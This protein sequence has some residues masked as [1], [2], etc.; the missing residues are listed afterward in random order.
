L[1]GGPLALHPS[2]D[3]VLQQAGYTV[4]RV[5]GVNQYATA[6]A[7]AGLMPN[8]AAVFEATGLHF[9]DAL[10]AVPAAIKAGGA[11]LLTDGASQ[12]GETAAYLQA[13][14]GVAR[15]AIGGPLAAAGADPGAEAVYGADL[16]DTSAAVAARFFSAPT[17][18]G[19]AS[20]ANFPDALA[21]GV[22]MGMPGH[23]GPMLLVSP[24]LPLPSAVAG[25]LATRGSVAG[26]FLFGGPLAV[27]DAVADALAL[28][29]P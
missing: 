26:A 22:F 14:P 10:S 5:Q 8:V 21:G 9:A 18:F 28:A 29:T 1:L 15:F 24:T 23:V 20:G 27:A 3:G 17:T 13:H 4:V 11:I 16:Y 2:I 12:S 6:V 19:A 25:Y 7:I